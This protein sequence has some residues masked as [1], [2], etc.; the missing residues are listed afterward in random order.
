M[1]SEKNIT[2]RLYWHLMWKMS[3]QVV[4]HQFDNWFGKADM[5]GINK[6]LFMHEMEIKISRSDFMSEMKDIEILSK[7]EMLGKDRWSKWLKHYNYLIAWDR[8]HPNQRQFLPN[9]FSFVVP[10]EL[11]EFC[12]EKL[13]HTP[14]WLIEIRQPNMLYFETVKKA[15]KLHSRKIEFDALLKL[16]HRMSYI[17]E[18][19]VCY[20]PNNAKLP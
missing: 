16:S 13:E 14:Y 1:V 2:K 20:D 9:Y 11:V 10:T 3:Y 12:K 6:N 4:A 19:L 7:G 18:N 17:C 15:K 5:F 8:L